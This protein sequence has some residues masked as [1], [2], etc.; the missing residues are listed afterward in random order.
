MDR[1]IDEL[2]KLLPKGLARRT[3]GLMILVVLIGSNVY[4]FWKIDELSLEKSHL[5][6][7]LAPFQAAAIRAFPG[8]AES[9][10]F[11]ELTQRVEKLA[12]QLE[13][14]RSQDLLAQVENCFTETALNTMAL[15]ALSNAEM[16]T[17]SMLAPEDSACGSLSENPSAPANVRATLKLNSVDIGKAKNWF[18]A[19]RTA[20]SR[21]G[22]TENNVKTAREIASGI[23][24]RTGRLKSLLADYLERNARPLPVVEAKEDGRHLVG[25]CSPQKWPDE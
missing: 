6:E 12:Q 8:V 25:M 3:V 23:L 17:S 5:E 4:A 19:L 15:E 13:S 9:E 7:V 2:I 18:E 24:Q 11:L 14:S 10:A 1:L 21:G 20:C 22:M 16:G